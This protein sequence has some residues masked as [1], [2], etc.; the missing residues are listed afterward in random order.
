MV[1]KQRFASTGSAYDLVEPS[2]DAELTLVTRDTPLGELL[3][4]YWHPIMKSDKVKDLPVKVRLLGEDLIIFRKPDGAVGLVYPRCIHRGTDLIY[5][6]VTDKGLRCCYHGWTFETDGRCTDQP[7]Q[8]ST[9]SNSLRQPWYP[10]EERYSMIFAYL[11]PIDR[12][13]PLPRYDLLEQLPEGWE[14]VADD[15][16]I[17]AGGAGRMPCNWL[18][19]HENGMDPAHVPIVH[20][21]QFPEIMTSDG[22]H[23]FSRAPDRIHGQG[24]MSMGAIT[25]KFKVELI[26]PNIRVIPDPLLSAN[27][28][29]GKSDSVAWT[30]PIDNENTIVFTAFG[31]PKGTV[32]SGDLPLYNGK[33]WRDLTAEEHQRFPGDFEAQVGQ[34][35]ITY[36][37]EEHLIRADQGIV[38]LRRQLREAIHA[39]R[40]GLDPPLA[41]GPEQINIVTTSGVTITQNETAAEA[42]PV[43][44]VTPVSAAAPAVQGRWNIVI[45]TPL[46]DKSAVLNCIVNGAALTGALVD[47]DGEIALDDGKVN[48]ME[49]QWSSK[50]T[51]PMP[52]TLKFSA[53]VTG[54]SINGKAKHMMGSAA[55]SGTRA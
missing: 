48:G 36:H 25:M 12:K 3:R 51:K 39:V 41:F 6:K 45:K 46:G 13:P 15:T 37:S 27:R 11:G 16:T 30:V 17:P 2:Y 1:D 19:H 55:F 5:G 24:T 42:A 26:L 53:T 22:K 44:P 43:A 8:S 38:F 35:S 18:Q 47:E 31:V 23:E 32:P 10:T 29:D 50:M 14:V 40:D 7:G 49:V 28:P 21:T 33:F 20:A 52:M 54:N 34:G 9:G 4:R